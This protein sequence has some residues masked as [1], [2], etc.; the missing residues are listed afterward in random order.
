MS[1]PSEPRKPAFKLRLDE[2]SEPFDVPEE[3]R[4][5]IAKELYEVERSDYAEHLR[6]Q[7]SVG[8]MALRSLFLINGGA[9]IG[10]L[11]FIGNHGADIVAPTIR[12]SI[13]LFVL[14]LAAAVAAP[15]PGYLA[16]LNNQDAAYRQMLDYLRLRL[17]AASTNDHLRSVRK[18]TWQLRVGLV[19]AILS[20]FFFAGGALVAINS[21]VL[22][23]AGASLGIPPG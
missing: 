14:G 1:R 12:W 3:W 13:A 2:E 20:L 8:T 16:Q 21:L 15:I 10:I 19:L 7:A 23:D 9:I 6:L 11:T 4:E 22:K 5:T 18:A 17:S